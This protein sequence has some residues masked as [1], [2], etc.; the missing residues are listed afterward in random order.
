MDILAH[1]GFWITEEEQNTPI[2]IERA[3][4]NG[5]GIETDLRDLAGEVVISHDC[6][7]DEAVFTFSEL[8]DLYKKF[9]QSLKLALNV[10]SDG[11]QNKCK[12]LLEKKEIDLK[13]V[14]FFDM[15]VPDGLQYLKYNL[16]C[17]T[18]YSDEETKPAF[19]DRALGIWVD[20]FQKDCTDECILTRL[21]EIGLPLCFVSPELHHRDHLD[22]WTKWHSLLG[23]KTKQHMICTDFPDDASKFYNSA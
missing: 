10:K 7:T 19:L 23:H 12:S 14:F 6:P 20:G 22:V 1:R 9:G 5:Y 17:F 4:V 11:L 21:L 13:N 15:S 16:P 3:F 8:L 18:R 2:A